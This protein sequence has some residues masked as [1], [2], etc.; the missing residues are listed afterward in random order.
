MKRIHDSLQRV[1]Q[2]H[3]L[4]FWYDAS[5]EWKD[6]F[7][8]YADAGVHKLIVAGNEFGTKVRVVREPDTE[9]RFLI[10]V[11]IA[12]PADGDNWL[13]DLLLQ[14]YEYKADKASLALQEVGLPHE[15]LHLTED[16]APYFTNAKRVEALK[17]VIGKD[18][19]SREIQL[20]SSRE[21]CV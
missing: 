21:S 15:F 6:T 9:A 1:F 2:R 7:Q 5:G 13:L 8:S 19:Q 20:A 14:G 12:R 11:P 3:R 10:Y 4:V 18:D 17:D 16:H